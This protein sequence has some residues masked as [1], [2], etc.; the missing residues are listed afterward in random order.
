MYT[1]HRIFLCG[2]VFDH[3]PNDN[4]ASMGSTGHHP[5]MELQEHASGHHGSQVLDASLFMALSSIKS[6]HCELSRALTWC[7]SLLSVSGTNTTTESNM[8][9]KGL[10]STY[11]SSFQ[12]VGHNTFGG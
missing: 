7:P 9:R 1:L 11:S 12:P 6:L 4:R 3:H 5:R 8:G 10:I 2:G